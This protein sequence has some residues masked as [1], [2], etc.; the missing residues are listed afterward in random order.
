MP[1]RLNPKA[2]RLEHRSPTPFKDIR[3]EQLFQ[4]WLL[5]LYS[6][7]ASLI[8]RSAH[9]RKNKKIVYLFYFLVYYFA[10]GDPHFLQK[11][12]VYLF[13]VLHN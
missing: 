2:E 3:L 10:I 11:K 12:A 7:I 5:N 1:K 13:C 4:I 8:S 9:T 6:F